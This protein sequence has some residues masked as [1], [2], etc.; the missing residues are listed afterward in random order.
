MATTRAASASRWA[1]VS[2][3]SARAPPGPT[4]VPRVQ[5]VVDL[6]SLATSGER[7]CQPPA[8]QK[9]KPSAEHDAAPQPRAASRPKL[10]A[11]H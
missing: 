6:R 3:L 7:R 11:Q 9:P 5:P 1:P 8:C 10:R 4:S 2:A